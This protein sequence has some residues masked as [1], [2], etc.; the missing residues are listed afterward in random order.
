M[1][2]LNNK[3]SIGCL[4]QW[5]EIEILHEYLRSVKNSLDNIENKD[6]VLIDLYFNMDQSLEKLDSEKNDISDIRNKFYQ[7]LDDIFDYNDDT[8]SLVGCNYNIKLNIN[9]IKNNIYTIAD[10]RREF[11]D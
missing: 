6:N 2:K 5:Y 1:V 3:F 4:V 10:Y 7:I 8:V 11:N 9:E